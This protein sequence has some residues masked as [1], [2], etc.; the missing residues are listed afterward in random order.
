MIK[1]LSFARRFHFVLEADGTIFFPCK[2][3]LEPTDSF[4]SEFLLL[5]VMLRKSFY[6]ALVS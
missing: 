5:G 6:N 4:K 2:D 3:S 1:E